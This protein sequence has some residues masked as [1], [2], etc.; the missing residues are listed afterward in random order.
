MNARFRIQLSAIIFDRNGRSP[1]SGFTARVLHEAHAVE[2]LEQHG[3]LTENH[4]GLSIGVIVG[5]YL[6]MVVAAWW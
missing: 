6:V 2:G 5:D 1:S 4:L 3:R